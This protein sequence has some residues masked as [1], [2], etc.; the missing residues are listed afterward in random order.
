MRI[1]P[2][3]AAAITLIGPADSRGPDALVTPQPKDGP[4]RLIRA[5]CAGIVAKVRRAQCHP[6]AAA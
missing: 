3:N 4:R 5:V 2:T 6:A 1:H